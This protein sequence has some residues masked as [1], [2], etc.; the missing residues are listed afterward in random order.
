[1]DLAKLDQFEKL[2]ANF[3][4]IF[5]TLFQDVENGLKNEKLAPFLGILGPKVVGKLN[6][7]KT[8]S[9]VHFYF[10]SQ[11]YSYQTMVEL[12]LEDD[13]DAKEI[14]FEELS[15]S[16]FSEEFQDHAKQFGNHEGIKKTLALNEQQLVGLLHNHIIK[17]EVVD[18]KI[19]EE[20]GDIKNQNN[21][22]ELSLYD[23]DEVLVDQV[24][25]KVLGPK[26]LRNSPPLK[27]AIEIIKEVSPKSFL[28]LQHFTQAIIPS[29]R[30]EIVS[31]SIQYLPGFSVINTK[32]RDN[33]DLIDDILHENGHHHLNYF[34][35]N[36]E[37]FEEVP[38]EIFYSPWRKSLRPLRGIYHGT[39]TFFFAQQ[40]FL[41]LA[42]YQKINPD[43]FNTREIKKIYQRLIEETVM[44]EFTFDD[45]D[46]AYNQGWIFDNGYELMQEI[47]QK[48]KNNIE[49]IKEL[50]SDLL[51][52]GYK[53]NEKLISLLKKQK[54]FYQKEH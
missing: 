39:I 16:M 31:Y 15:N 30:E 12:F 2:K 3:K 42:A 19:Y 11:L 25:I 46:W 41:D 13:D 40:I 38:D 17:D 51:E 7:L 8:V 26:N 36:D 37:L 1:M 52:T 4:K 48:I 47:I 43:F 53:T 28:R 6:L 27:K 50:D 21:K 34:L 10:L 44:L 22:I 18:Y 45:I 9:S 14:L 32:H 54:K 24:K 33:I 49:K 35:N 29:A 5:L 23:Y 20:L